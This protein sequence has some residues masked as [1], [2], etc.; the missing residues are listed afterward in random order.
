MRA[1]ISGGGGAALTPW[2]SHSRG[3]PPERW[4]GPDPLERAPLPPLEGP[5]PLDGG[6]GGSRSPHTR[7]G[8]SVRR[9]RR[10]RSSRGGLKPLAGVVRRRTD[11]RTD[12]PTHTAAAREGRAPRAGHAGIGRSHGWG[13][14]RAPRLAHARRPLP[15]AACAGCPPHPPHTLTHTH[16]RPIK[17]GGAGRA[18]RCRRFPPPRDPPAPQR[19][20][21]PSRR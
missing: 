10:G 12:R 16:P 13:G 1:D 7:L 9:R 15:S 5:S 14:A 6:P 11:G 3:G 2:W 20:P 4:A 21:W 18:P 8:R 19:R 17:A